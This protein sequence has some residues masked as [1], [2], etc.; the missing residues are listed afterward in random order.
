MPTLSQKA[1]LSDAALQEYGGAH[2]TMA[3][4]A[5]T[6]VDMLVEGAFT[7]AE[8]LAALGQFVA[9]YRMRLARIDAARSP[10]VRM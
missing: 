5:A 1:D 2:A 7:P 3:A 9:E 8:A 6:V 10:G 4:C